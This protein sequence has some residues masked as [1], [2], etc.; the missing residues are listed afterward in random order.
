M[1]RRSLL[2]VLSLCLGCG[3]PV[4]SQEVPAPETPAPSAPRVSAR[5]ERVARIFEDA[6]ARDRFSGVVLVREHGATLVRAHGWAD[7]EAKR[8]NAP[9][10][11]FRIGSMTKGF[12]AAA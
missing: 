7:A 6:A 11:I 1:A 5:A 3:A 10:T 9:D 12:T 8:A 4:V 2:L